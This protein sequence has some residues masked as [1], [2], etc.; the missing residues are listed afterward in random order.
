MLSRH[1]V[2]VDVPPERLQFQVKLLAIRRY[3]RQPPQRLQFLPESEQIIHVAVMEV[4]YRV[5]CRGRDVA[6]VTADDVV[7]LTVRVV[8]Q[9]GEVSEVC[10][11][12]RNLYIV[13]E[14]VAGN[15]DVGSSSGRGQA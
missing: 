11:V 14:Y 13:G 1:L 3:G 2:F 8:Q 4:E 5:V 7:D 12:Q 15:V 6:H 9:A 10:L